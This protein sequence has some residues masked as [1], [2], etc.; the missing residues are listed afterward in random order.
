MIR[1]TKQLLNI[2]QFPGNHLVACLYDKI[3]SSYFDMHE[4]VEHQRTS[5]QCYRYLKKTSKYAALFYAW[6]SV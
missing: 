1:G 3:Y 5:T 2:K 4:L 6:K